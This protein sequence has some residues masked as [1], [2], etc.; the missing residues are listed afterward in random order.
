MDNMGCG[1]VLSVSEHENF[2]GGMYYSTLFDV[3]F[4]YEFETCGLYTRPKCKIYLIS[5][6]QGQDLL[7][8]LPRKQVKYK[9]T[10][11]RDRDSG[12]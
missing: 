7:H 1:P 4:I 2:H 5:T 11:G 9:A 6:E 10:K 8:V 3:Q 12:R